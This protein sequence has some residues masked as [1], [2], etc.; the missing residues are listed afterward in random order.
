MIQL[1]SS[2]LMKPAFRLLA[3]LF[4]LTG[5][6]AGCGKP[7]PTVKQEPPTVTVSRPQ[8][9]QVNDYLDLTG[10]VAPSRS[11]DLVARVTG[12]LRSVNFQDG[13]MVKEGDLLFLIEPEPYQAQLDLATAAEERAKAEYERQE[14]LIRSNATSR[15]NLEKWLSD[16]DQA[17]AQ[18]ELAKIN[19]SYTQVLAPFSG[20]MG[21]RLVDPGNLV[22][23]SVN[24]KLANIEELDP[25]YVYFSL[26]E[27]DALQGATIMRQRGQKPT[28]SMGKATVLVGLQNQE[29]YPQ[30]GVL[31]FVDTGIG[32]SSGTIQ[33]RAIFANK[34][35][36]L[37]PG[38]FARVRIPL[39]DPKPMLVVP[40]SA[41]GNDQEG[42]Y[43]LVVGADN[44]VVRRSVEKGTLTKTG[45]AIRSG[46]NAE[47]RVIV[48]GQVRTKPGSKVTPVTETAPQAS[49]QSAGEGPSPE[50]EPSRLAALEYGTAAPETNDADSA[51]VAA[52]SRD[53]SRSVG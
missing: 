48:K 9:E 8:Q 25:I 15:A 47:D 37:V 30:E 10:T 43:V 42:D 29:G 22:G 20:R 28:S 31:D 45:C 17:R 1:L 23:P 5:L 35:R 3:A 11:V 34:E 49:T 50:R 24:T 18:V 40:R 2:K 26:N 46:L 16:R 53:G 12:Y 6:L 32:T 27:R 41:L 38:A 13:T 4:A 21:R 36:V 19:L 44:V 33:M 7:A 52:A 51:W 39:G 14:F